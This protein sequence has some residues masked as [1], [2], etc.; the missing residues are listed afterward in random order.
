M[1]VLGRIKP[2]D[3]SYIIFQDI[4]TGY[5]LTTV[6]MFVVKA[7]LFDLIGHGEFSGIN[8][9]KRIGWEEN[10]GVRFL[11]CLNFLG[12]LEKKDDLFYPSAFS[13]RFLLRESENYQGSS[14]EFEEQLIES[15]G[16]LERTLATGKRVYGIEDKTPE[17]YRRALEKY[18]NSMDDAACIRAVEL[19]NHIQPTEM[20]VILDIGAG[21][22]A[23]LAEFLNRHS[24]WRGIF[25]DLPDVIAQAMKN[26]K[27][28]GFG[29]R[30]S[31]CACN[32]LDSELKGMISKKV[33]IV[34]LSNILHCQGEVENRELFKKVM[35]TVSDR[36][37][38]IVHDF[39]KDTGWRGALYDIHMMLNTY[40]G[41]TYTT[42]EIVDM[43]KKIGFRYF[44]T[45]QFPSKSTAVVA[46]REKKSLPD[47]DF[48]QR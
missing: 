12:L 5:R 43:I 47:L 26:P 42:T 46:S 6:L 32:L 35:T 29:D 34:L 18:I 39:F 21:S 11:D 15:W 1:Q 33:D 45:V 17:D 48:V 8:I 20:G 36:G 7:G 22:G 14:L 38:I 40:N 3:T 10:A 23:F 19:W 2:D 24:G 30:I 4:L 9:C 37:L 27:L 31:W 13:K 44:V 41:R 16:T 25:C 28:N